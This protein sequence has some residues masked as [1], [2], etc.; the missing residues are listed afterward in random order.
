[1]QR[2]KDLA[3]KNRLILVATAIVM[4]ALLIVL[5]GQT[6][7][8]N[9]VGTDKRACDI[10]SKEVIAAV[11][12]GLKLSKSKDTPLAKTDDNGVRNSTCEYSEPKLDDGTEFV[13]SLTMQTATSKAAATYLNTQFKNLST[14]SDVETVYSSNRST[15]WNSKTGQAYILHKNT[16][17]TAKYGPRKAYN[18]EFGTIVRLLEPLNTQLP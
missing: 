18:P 12:T 3:K 1:M 17:Y 13:V 7:R 4:V 5:I 15:Y 2:V 6:P 11:S 9:T 8:K 10:L 14:S 16:L